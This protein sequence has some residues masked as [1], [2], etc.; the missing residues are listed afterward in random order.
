MAGVNDWIHSIPIGDVQKTFEDTQKGILTDDTF[1]G[2]CNQMFYYLRE[3]YPNAQII[4]LGTHFADGTY[5]KLFDGAGG[6]YNKQGLT[7]VEYGDVLCEVAQLW[8]ID[9]INIGRELSWNSGNIMEYCID[10]IHFNQEKG[11]V[12][13]AKVII[14]FMKK[15]NGV[16]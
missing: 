10:G 14:K 9:N 2:A 1:A 11:S 6:I 16:M 5:A 4:V 8:G 12:E 7:S 15:L 13:A 3:L